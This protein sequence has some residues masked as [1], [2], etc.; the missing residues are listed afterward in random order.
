MFAGARTVV[1]SLWK[2]ADDPTAT[3]MIDFHGALHDGAEPGEAL[4]RARERAYARNP[5]PYL[6]APLVLHGPTDA[7]RARSDH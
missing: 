3:F 1:V 4:R 7:P 5:D 6:W 2:I